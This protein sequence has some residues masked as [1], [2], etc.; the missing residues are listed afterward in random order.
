MM[1]LFLSLGFCVVVIFI[2]FVEL[3]VMIHGSAAK[4]YLFCRLTEV[5]PLLKES[6]A[7]PSSVEYVS[8]LMRELKLKDKDLHSLVLLFKPQIISQ[9]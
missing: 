6:L 9:D 3:I 1:W 7:R 8:S 4:H 2:K 5:S